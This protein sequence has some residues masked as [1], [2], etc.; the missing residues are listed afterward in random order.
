MAQDSIVS[1]SPC[2]SSCEVNDLGQIPQSSSPM[3]VPS[4]RCSQYSTQSS[5]DASR[6]EFV[7]P[8][9][10]KPTIMNA[11]EKQQLNPE[12]RNEIVRDLVTHVYAH[13]EKPTMMCIG[14]VARKLVDKYPF[15][16]D[17]GAAHFVSFQYS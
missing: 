17:T 15:M 9:R 6:N 3:P 4:S 1:H 11:I 10:W 2:E 14:D 16:S 12:V 5:N 7:I 13:V 8:L